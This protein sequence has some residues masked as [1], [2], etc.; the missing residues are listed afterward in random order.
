[1]EWVL[2]NCG[3]QGKADAAAANLPLL[4]Q[5]KINN[6]TSLDPLPFESVKCGSWEVGSPE[7]AGNW[8]AVGFYFARSI[9]KETGVPIGLVN[10]SWGGTP[11]Q[12]W[13]PADA[14]AS[15]PDFVK[16]RETIENRAEIIKQNAAVEADY[17]A[18]QAATNTWLRPPVYPWGHHSPTA[19]YNAMIYGLEQMPIRGFI[20][21]QGENNATDKF[22]DAR[23]VAMVA[24]WRKKWNAPL[25]FYFVQLAAHMDE[26]DDPNNIGWE[27][28]KQRERQTKAW[29]AIPNSGMA[30]A[31]DIGEGKDVHPKN[32]LDVGERLARWALRDC[33][34]K[35]ITVS[36]PMMK[37]IKYDKDTATVQFEYA[38]NGLM[39]G[40]KDSPAPVVEDKNAPLLGFAVKGEKSGK[41]AWA[42]AS[43]KGNTVLLKHP[44]QEKVIGVRYAYQSNP[45]VNFYN[46]D[47][48]P[49]VPFTTD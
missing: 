12:A 4:R 32:K 24:S 3:D 40:K 16:E 46:R 25:P 1:M 6:A 14:F 34:G 11:I 30:L 19:L 27:W 13:M 7:R 26:S 47:G 38:E 2:K 28:A 23:M 18:R 43:I 33:Y 45:K 44:Q 48:L 8:T 17:K 20:W 35:K 9:L 39:V 22:Y 10:S 15:N 29:K 49:G 37:S 36:G 41:W 21:Y 31:I 5:I 42:Q